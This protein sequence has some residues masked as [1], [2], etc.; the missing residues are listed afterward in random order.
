MNC[1]DVIFEIFNEIEKTLDLGYSRLYVNVDDLDNGYGFL[2]LL[3]RKDHDF[4][5]VYERV[6]DLDLCFEILKLLELSKYNIR[7]FTYFFDFK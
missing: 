1:D 7:D 6:L 2:R 5:I 4:L 3:S